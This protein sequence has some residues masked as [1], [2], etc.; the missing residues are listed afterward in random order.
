MP[1]HLGLQFPTIHACYFS[2]Y[3]SC[4]RWWFHASPHVEM[5]E[6]EGGIWP[7][8]PNIVDDYA[9]DCDS[10][11][12]NVV[13]LDPDPTPPVFAW[14][15]YW[16]N[17][18]KDPFAPY[19]CN[20]HHQCPK[21][22][23]SKH[24][25]GWLWCHSNCSFYTMDNLTDLERTQYAYSIRSKQILPTASHLSFDAPSV[26]EWKIWLWIEFIHSFWRQK[27]Q[28]AKKTIQLDGKPCVP[29]L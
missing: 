26:E 13:E 9:H 5:S 22:Q 4:F 3:C 24:D 7:N 8:H 20:L 2:W 23:W 17:H 12:P 25:V 18:C 21:W 15:G 16:Y 11:G 10:V 19:K 1:M 27:L 29:P 28:Q 6:S 14:E